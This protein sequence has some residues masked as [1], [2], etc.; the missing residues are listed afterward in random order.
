[1]PEIVPDKSADRADW[2]DLAREYD[3]WEAA[4][5]HPTLW[6]RDDDAVADSPALRQLMAVARVPVALA[7]IPLAPD[8]PL[9]PSLAGALADW[10]AA[11]V[12][13]H[14]IAHRNR[15]AAPAKKS[16]FPPEAPAAEIAAGL[17][18]GR[19]RLQRDFG[20]RFLPVLTPP[21]NRIAPDW[22]GSLPG[23]GYGGLSRFGEP[24]Y[25]AP[26]AVAGL[27]QVNTHVD[28]IDWR[29]GGGFRGEA[30]CLGRLVG[31]LAARR[32]GA[33]VPDQPTGLLTHHLV[34]DAATWRFLDNL[35]D[36]LARRGRPAVFCDARDLWPPRRE[37][38]CS[39]MSSK[40][41]D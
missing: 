25:A 1:M 22:V 14:G 38:N 31:H 9:Q 12:L 3:R 35:Q 30:P 13:Q 11:S 27:H 41:H 39:A 19:A 2:D 6:W 23:L 24:P 17:A 34:H 33:A 32:T 8:R 5:R 18:E 37:G 21:W 7:V 10:P 20:A 36:W 40:Q 29:G 28:V 26:P 16:E 4:G 15:A